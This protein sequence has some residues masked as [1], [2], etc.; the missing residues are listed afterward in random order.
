M[1][2]FYQFF[3]LLLTTPKKLDVVQSEERNFFDYSSSEK[4]RI[5]RAAGR[6]AQQEQQK[7]L[8]KYEARY[9]STS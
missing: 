1:K 3:S 4:I 5:L 7:L 2:L 6:D 8:K 9:G